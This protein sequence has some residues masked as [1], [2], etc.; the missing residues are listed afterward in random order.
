MPEL[1]YAVFLRTSDP[2]VRPQ[3]WALMPAWQ[4]TDKC[5]HIEC[6]A[7]RIMAS[8]PPVGEQWED[9]QEI[10]VVPVALS[11]RVLVSVVEDG[12]QPHDA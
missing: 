6:V 3:M 10:I 9:E 2:E 11:A 4:E 8:T 7:T 5:E 12:W 1:N